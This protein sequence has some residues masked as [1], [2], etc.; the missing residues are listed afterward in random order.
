[1]GAAHVNQVGCMYVSDPLR[2]FQPSLELATPVALVHDPS[3]PVLTVVNG[4]V[5]E[6]P[7]AYEYNSDSSLPPRSFVYG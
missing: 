7:I 6:P 2:C 4:G 5:P 1:M 3:V